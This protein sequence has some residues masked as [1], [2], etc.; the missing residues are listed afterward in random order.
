MGEDS[1]QRRGEMAA[2]DLWSRFVDLA[3]MTQRRMHTEVAVLPDAVQLAVAY[4]VDQL[5]LLRLV[6]QLV[7]D[8]LHRADALGFDALGLRGVD[9]GTKDF[10][11]SVAAVGEPGDLLDEVR[12]HRSPRRRDRR[13]DGSGVV[14]APR[15]LGQRPDVRAPDLRNVTLKICHRSPSPA[16]HRPLCDRP[17]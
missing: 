6:E 16:R 5:E 3:E 13:T 9:F 2:G 1:G 8:L 14:A 7:F 4:G 11:V 17:D 12:R 10:R 15:L